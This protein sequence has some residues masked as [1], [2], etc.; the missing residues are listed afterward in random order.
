MK[1]R[2]SE[3]RQALA[4]QIAELR[5]DLLKMQRALEKN[6]DLSDYRATMLR[7]SAGIRWLRIA[8]EIDGEVAT[9]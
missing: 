5:G 2:T 1:N 3:E 8:K 7:G 9:A 6:D 4:A